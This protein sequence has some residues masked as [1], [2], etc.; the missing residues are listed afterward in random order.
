MQNHTFNLQ[1]ISNQA[2]CMVIG[3]ENA[4]EQYGI[5]SHK[6][7]PIHTRTY[8]D[9]QSGKDKEIVLPNAIG[10]LFILKVKNVYWIDKVG[11][12]TEDGHLF[13]PFYTGR[14]DTNFVRFDHTD[15]L[16]A[17][18]TEH[19]RNYIRQSSAAVVQ[20]EMFLC[21]TPFAHYGHFILESL[22]R[23]WAM[24]HL[25]DVPTLF[26]SEPD[27]GYEYCLE[28]LGIE[29]KLCWSKSRA[30]FFPEL[31][32]AT[33]PYAIAQYCTL[34]AQETWQQIGRACTQQVDTSALPMDTFYVSRKKIFSNR[35]L[36][37]EELLES[38][39]NRKGFMPFCPEDRDFLEQLILFST[40]SAIIAPYGS[41]IFTTLFNDRGV[42][43]FL[44]SP[45]ESHLHH[46]IC[47]S[48]RFPISV[49]LGEKTETIEKRA[50]LHGQHLTIKTFAWN[51]PDKTDLLRNVD[52]WIHS[53]KT[54]QA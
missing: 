40:A 25:P 8:F 50:F 19:A 54:R 17:E 35:V 18:L 22:P 48:D 53:L 43:I 15:P 30:V 1:R 16:S 29:A 37:E 44:L 26:I 31:Y 3:H 52:S 11:L 41:A 9:C 7:S 5:H 47:F 4:Y 6:P 21:S 51:I 10:D 24:E 39:F 34:E 33:Q 23:L 38:I 49:Y 36:L 32:L 27:F 20:E 12:F 46:L 13:H 45:S 42:E 28:A 2:S 14:F